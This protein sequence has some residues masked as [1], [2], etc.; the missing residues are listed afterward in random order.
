MGIKIV[1]ILFVVV[2]WWLYK[3]PTL[4]EK[5][6]EVDMGRGEGERPSDEMQGAEGYDNRGFILTTRL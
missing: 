1:S 6:L 4:E 3:P 5:A 2:C